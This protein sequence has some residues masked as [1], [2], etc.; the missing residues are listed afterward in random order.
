MNDIDMNPHSRDDEL[1]RRL[2]AYGRARLSPDTAS[3]ARMRARVVLEAQRRSP[4]SA[5]REPVARPSTPA[6]VVP[7]APRR[8]GILP[9]L[10]AA[11][12]VVLMLA[13]GAL[14]ARP[15]GPL[16]EARLAVEAAFLPS[17][18]EARA[19]ANLR[20]LEARLAE[21]VEAAANRD[22]RGVAAALAA[23]RRLVDETA[24]ASGASDVRD[25]VL[26]DALAKHLDVLNDLLSRVPDQ[27]RPAIEQA[28]ERSDK[29]VEKI[30]QGGGPKP[31][32][33]TEPD[34]GSKPPNEPP[35]QSA[36]PDL[37]PPG[38]PSERPSR[39]P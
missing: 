27:A 26:E 32:P 17:G 20:R 33:G 39:A 6:V 4:T 28:I 36:K 1:K 2:E 13:G 30:H 16:Y 38:P 37:T 3:S 12:L 9:A 7:L 25:A 5:S 22:G 15:G 29:A 24:G 11:A 35:G 23:Y 18:A 8:R 10:L 21:A 19:E 34:P 14:A 31:S